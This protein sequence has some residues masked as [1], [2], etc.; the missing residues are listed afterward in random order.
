[1]YTN[2]VPTTLLK[3]EVDYVGAQYEDVLTIFLIRKKV[4]KLS[5]ST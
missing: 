4:K 5:K 3:W 2:E 1:M